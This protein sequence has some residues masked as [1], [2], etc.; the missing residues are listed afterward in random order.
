MKPSKL[1]ELRNCRV[2]CIALNQ[3]GV[4]FLFDEHKKLM[5]IGESKF[6]LVR[7][8]DHYHK[9]YTKT[10]GHFLKPMTS[11]KGIG[12]IFSYF[13]IFNIHSE[14][15][16]IRQHYEKRWMKK[17]KPYLNFKTKNVVYDLSWKEINGHMY[18]YDSHFKGDMTWHRYINDEVLRK[19]DEFKKYNSTRRRQY[20]EKF[21]R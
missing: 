1:L 6:P 21:G 8:L 10:V 12:P 5:Y 9:H 15:S 14:D 11:K 16:R 2:D 4:Y 7:V 18:L 3:P 17:F 19:R 13:K 20:Y